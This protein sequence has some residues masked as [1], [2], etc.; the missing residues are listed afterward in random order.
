MWPMPTYTP[1][2]QLP[3]NRFSQ[4]KEYSPQPTRSQRSWASKCG[5]SQRA[6]Q[7]TLHETGRRSGGVSWWNFPCVWVLVWCAHIR[8]LCRA[9]TVQFNKAPCSLGLERR[10][11][12]D[13]WRALTM[14]ENWF[15]G[16]GG[17]KQS[18]R[19]L[20]STTWVPLPS[21]YWSSKRR[22]WELGISCRKFLCCLTPR[23]SGWLRPRQGT[24]A[25]FAPEGEFPNNSHNWQRVAPSGFWW[26]GSK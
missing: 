15:V 9:H 8:S 4:G 12:S 10:P 18:S 23:C 1:Y 3:W 17:W 5:C 25:L 6:L 20:A 2:T 19:S 26:L 14:L 22:K 24:A 16:P 21:S 7:P 13:D 11:V